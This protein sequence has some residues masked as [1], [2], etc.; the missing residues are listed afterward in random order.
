LIRPQA[1]RYGGEPIVVKAGSFLA[2]PINLAD[3]QEVC[4]FQE[5]RYEY[6][7]RRKSWAC[8]DPLAPYCET[9]RYDAFAHHLAAFETTDETIQEKQNQK[10]VIYLR[11]LPWHE[12]VGFMLDHEFRCLL[13]D[14][15]HADLHRTNAVELSRLVIAPGACSKSAN[16]DGTGERPRHVIELLLKLL[17]HLSLEQQIEHYYI[18]VEKHWLPAFTRRFHIPFKVIGR[19]YTFPDG[20]VTVAAHAT[21]TELEQAMAAKDSQK[22]LWYQQRD[23]KQ[24]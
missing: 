22:F 6:F 9:D 5:L 17:Y 23:A 3:P 11:A 1:V 14:E 20:T 18:V 21:R 15:E 10:I 12:H 4:T 16:Q 8:P 7:V 2:R 13:S 24:P 19:E